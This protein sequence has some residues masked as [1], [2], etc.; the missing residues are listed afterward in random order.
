M[1]TSPTPAFHHNLPSTP[2]ASSTSLAEASV[3]TAPHSGRVVKQS[4][5]SKVPE[6]SCSSPKVPT[7]SPLRPSSQVRSRP[8]SAKAT[9]MHSAYADVIPMARTYSDLLPSD[10]SNDPYFFPSTINY[11]AHHV[12]G[13]PSTIVL[14]AADILSPTSL[15]F[16]SDS[17]SSSPENLSSPEERVD[18]LFR[19][20]SSSLSGVTMVNSSSPS[21]SKPCLAS[22]PSTMTKRQYALHEL[23]SSERAYASD[24]ALIKDIHLP[25]A[26]G[27]SF[28]FFQLG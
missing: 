8:Q 14:S 26:L 24:L 22:H 12:S 11:S 7:R 6:L 28:E 16:K 10:V 23:L 4:S 25:L 15:A 13:D 2:L 9:P 5:I 18:T 19:R 17:R 21:S 3:V 27:E 1:R 20:G